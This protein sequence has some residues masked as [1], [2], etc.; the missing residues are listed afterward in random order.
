MVIMLT[1]RGQNFP[2]RSI[3]ESLTEMA[4]QYKREVLADGFGR[5]GGG[6]VGVDGWE[7]GGGRAFL[8]L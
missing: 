7:G 4:A 3:T 5:G 2:S 8:R 1:P 6:G